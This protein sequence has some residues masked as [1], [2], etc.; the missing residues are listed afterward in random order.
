MTDFAK[1]RVAL[2]PLAGV[3]DYSFRKICA[4]HK[5]EYCVTEM[6][7]AKAM[8]YNDKKTAELAYIRKSE[9]MTA[10]QL[11]GSEP[12]I[13]AEAAKK[14]AENT[15]AYN[16]GSKIPAAIDINMGCPVHKIVS[17]GEGSALMR[18]PELVGRIIR[19]AVDAQPLPVT[20]KIRAGW[21]SNSINAVEIAKIAEDNGAS[22]I[23]V[24]GRTREEM[25]I[26]S[27]RHDIIKAVKDSVSIP[28]F[29]NGGIMSAEDALKMLAD[30]NADGVMIARGAMGNPWIFEEIDAALN[31]RM[32]RRPERDEIISTALEHIRLMIEEKG[33][34]T[35]VCESRKHIACYTKG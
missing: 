8:H 5:M 25:Y 12:D 33:E 21:D 34:K 11:F 27:V 2:A 13:I 3:S 1:I 26:S 16:R 19:A 30:T 24:H 10:V 29:A 7:S 14:L 32:Y 4:D 35:G 15:Y 18:S 6:V 22:M 9:P 31:G 17:N 20:V 28:V 23:C